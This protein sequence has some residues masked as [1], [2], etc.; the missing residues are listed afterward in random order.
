MGFLHLFKQIHSYFATVLTNTHTEVFEIALYSCTLFCA[1]SKEESGTRAVSYSLEM[2]M[3]SCGVLVVCVEQAS[4]E[5]Q[6][7]N[8]TE[9]H[10][11]SNYCQQGIVRISSE[12]VLY[13]HNTL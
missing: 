9:T 8:Q 4:H 1:C 5:L 6:W 7:R 13:D 11:H 10:L 3:T 12:D 2:K